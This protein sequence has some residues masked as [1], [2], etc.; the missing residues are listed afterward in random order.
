MFEIRQA[1]KRCGQSAHGVGCDAVRS[2]L[3]A[4]ALVTLLLYFQLLPSCNSQAGLP[5]TPAADRAQPEAD[6]ALPDS[7]FGGLPSLESLRAT[8]QLLPTRHSLYGAEY[9]PQYSSP[10]TMLDY[11]AQLVSTLS[12]GM[13]RRLRDLR[14]QRLVC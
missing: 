14:S 10:E 1:G 6:S 8:A 3:N 13:G 4:F 12:A 5:P 7:P 2:L 9:L 11:D